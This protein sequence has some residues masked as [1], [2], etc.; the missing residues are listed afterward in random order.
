MK[1]EVTQEKIKADIL[2]EARVL[3]IQ[4]GTAEIIADKV[5]E[6]VFGW[7]KKRSIITV[8]D[9]NHQI[10]KEVAKFNKDL[11]Y[12]FESRGKII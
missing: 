5:S 4:I 8:D 3:K 9:L 12:L 1:E 7:S 10:A 11:A 6:K 2:R